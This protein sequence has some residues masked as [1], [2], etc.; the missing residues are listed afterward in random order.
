MAPVEIPCEAKIRGKVQ[1]GSR[2]K[3]MA[4]PG[5]GGALQKGKINSP[6]C[7]AFF[8]WTGAVASGSNPTQAAANRKKSSGHALVG[9]VAYVP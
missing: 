8:Y 5:G 3:S 7:E 9:A 6:E 1:A 4:G 2:W